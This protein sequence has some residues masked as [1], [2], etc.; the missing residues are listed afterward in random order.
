MHGQ[1][2]THQA[3]GRTQGT[4]DIPV[5]FGH[6]RQLVTTEQ[7]GLQQVDPFKPGVHLQTVQAIDDQRL[8]IDVLIEGKAVAQFI[9]QA[10]LEGPQ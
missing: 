9:Q 4:G 7:T 5:G 1:R 6:G 2:L 3:L 10:P 8:A